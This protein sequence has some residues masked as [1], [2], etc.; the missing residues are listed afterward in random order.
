M[1]RLETGKGRPAYKAWIPIPVLL[2]G[3]KTSTRIEPGKSIYAAV[4]PAAAQPG[5][6]D[7]AIWIGYAWADEPS[8]SR[9][10]DGDGRR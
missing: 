2:P 9:G 5:V 1:T 10:G 8:Q 6:I 3:E 4:A 7:A